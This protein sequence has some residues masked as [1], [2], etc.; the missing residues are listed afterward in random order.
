[1]RLRASCRLR[2]ALAHL[3]EPQAGSV[4]WV[5]RRGLM[6]ADEDVRPWSDAGVRQTRRNVHGFNC[7]YLLMASL[8]SLNSRD[9]TSPPSFID[10]LFRSDS[11]A[12]GTRCTIPHRI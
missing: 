11:A 1:M 8:Y 10:Q 5:V 9:A 6:R 4:R 7:C 2:F 3:T 12:M